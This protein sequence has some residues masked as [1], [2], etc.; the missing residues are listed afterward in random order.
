MHRWRQIMERNH[1]ETGNSNAGIKGFG[2]YSMYFYADGSIVSVY[3]M[4][5]YGYGGAVSWQI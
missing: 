4:V 5:C 2:I 3:G 1:L